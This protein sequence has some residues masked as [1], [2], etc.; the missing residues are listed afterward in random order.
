MLTVADFVSYLDEF[1]PPY[2][3]ESWDNVGLLVGD[4]TAPA[5]RVMTCLSIT[6]SS[7]AEAIAERADLIVTHQ[8]LPFRPLKQLTRATPEGAMLLDLIA[9]KINVYSP[10]TAFDSAA[11]GINAQWAAGLQLT[12]CQ[13]MIAKPAADGGGNVLGAG[14]FGELAKP[15]SLAQLA[16]RV[17]QFLHLPGVQVVGDLNNLMSRVAIACGSAGEFLPTARQLGCQVLLLGETR[18]HTLLEAEA[19]DMAL[20]LTGHYASERFGVER[21]AAVLAQRFPNTHVWPSTAERDPLQWV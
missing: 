12:N 5:A 7:V 3:A 20:I 17:K 14:R 8:P 18:F 11:H 13:P 6:P 16:E 19:T 2:L 4:A 1:A 21:L 10:H 9:A 15:L